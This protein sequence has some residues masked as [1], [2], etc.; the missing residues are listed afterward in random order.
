MIQ[1]TDSIAKS[2]TSSSSHHPPLD[3]TTQ[4]WTIRTVAEIFASHSESIRL[5]NW[6]KDQ[7]AL[8]IQ[9]P[10][11]GASW[12][13]P[14]ITATVIR[15]FKDHNRLDEMIKTYET[16][17]HPSRM[18]LKHPSSINNVFFQSSTDHAQHSITNDRSPRSSTQ[19]NPILTRTYHDLISACGRANRPHLAIHYLNE[20]IEI[21][22][23][24]VRSLPHHPIRPPPIPPLRLQPATFS[25]LIPNL[26]RKRRDT[27]LRSVLDL[28]NRLIRS[29]VDE[30]D[31]IRS[32]VLHQASQYP[33]ESSKWEDVLNSI[34]PDL[35]RSQ[36]TQT[37]LETRKMENTSLER[38]VFTRDLPPKLPER[39]RIEEEEEE[40]EDK[41]EGEG[42]PSD[43]LD[44]RPPML[45][46]GRR[47]RRPPEAR[48]EMDYLRTLERTKFLVKSLNHSIRWVDRLNHLILK[49]RLNRKLRFQSYLSN[50]QGRKVQSKDPATGRHPLQG[51]FSPPSRDLQPSTIGGD[52]AARHRIQDRIEAL[53]QQ[54]HRLRTWGLASD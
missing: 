46:V 32:F 17:R 19:I 37:D 21:N 25:D 14:K 41:E 8:D 40:E 6:L 53:N 47:R 22:Q 26:V 34:L 52:R 51:F 2:L 29:I 33:H 36:G 11:H 48:L 43:D 27:Q 35:D 45:S 30:L 42:E 7:R 28:T 50:Q 24:Y 39:A 23:A 20:A 13:D 12:T 49:S 15:Y 18:M 54:K 10:D 38:F 16:A 4:R 3:L 1:L 5:S 44:D 31:W 9:F